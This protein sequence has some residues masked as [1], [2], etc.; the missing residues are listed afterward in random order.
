LGAD[1]HTLVEA[2]C[3]GITLAVSKGSFILGQGGQPGQ[4]LEGVMATTKIASHYLVPGY[5]NDHSA[6]HSK[7]PGLKEILWMLLMFLKL[8]QEPHK[9]SWLLA[10][11]PNDHG[12]SLHDSP[13]KGVPC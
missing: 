7:L 13:A 4:W 6:F 12:T 10:M 2:L 9:V 3:T 5:T 8:H 1:S 11:A